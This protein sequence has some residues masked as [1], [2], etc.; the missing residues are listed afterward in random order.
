MPSVFIPNVKDFLLFSTLH[1]LMLNSLTKVLDL[2]V[3]LLKVLARI[4]TDGSMS[5]PH[6]D[7]LQCLPVAEL[8]GCENLSQFLSLLL[9]P[10]L[11]AVEASVDLF[12]KAVFRARLVVG[13]HWFDA[14][15]VHLENLLFCHAHLL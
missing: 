1:L 6:E 5:R 9:I 10:K 13:A 4:W 14:G 12:L 3:E 15:L 7:R 2:W 8:Q 11:E